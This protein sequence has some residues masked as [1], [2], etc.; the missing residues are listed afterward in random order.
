[1]NLKITTQ[2]EDNNNISEKINDFY[3]N[4]LDINIDSF[5]D[6]IKID[7]TI[8]FSEK[9]L[10]PDEFC[11]FMLELGR[12]CISI[13]KLNFANEIFKKI[14]KNSDKTLYKAES[15]LELANV[16]SRRADWPGCLRAVAEAETMYREINDSSGIAKCYN[17][18]GVI[19]GEQ[20]DIEK[21]KTYFLKSLSNINLEKD[22]EMAANL[23][24]N[25]G[26][27]E[28]IQENKDNA[29]MYL[30]NALLFYKKLGNQKRM[31][32]ANY[33]IGIASFE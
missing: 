17:L 28:N 20:G 11:E 26:L 10:I 8:T 5:N 4:Q 19:Y 2:K 15:K 23:N 25:L 24:S 29:K 27:I 30:K 32:E 16:F 1:M 21:A 14:I 7:K 6:R 22:L 12:L 9:Q 31:A 13:G 18:R 33:N 3:R